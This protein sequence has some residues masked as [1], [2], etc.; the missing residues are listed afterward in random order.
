MCIL[1]LVQ[2]YFIIYFIL[3]GLHRSV[4]ISVILA[5]VGALFLLFTII[6][7]CGLLCYFKFCRDRQN[8]EIPKVINLETTS[9]E[10]KPSI[11]GSFRNKDNS[12]ILQQSPSNI[13]SLWTFASDGQSNSI[14]ITIASSVAVSPGPPLP[15]LG[16]TTSMVTEDEFRLPNGVTNFARQNLKVLNL[17]MNVVTE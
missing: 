2:F 6:L 1:G 17:H 9:F 13:S 7:C 5:G 12:G 15:S 10:R 3:V 16:P 11:R 8:T 4:F 14:P